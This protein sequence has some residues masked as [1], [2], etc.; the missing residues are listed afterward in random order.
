M[1]FDSQK[2][3]TTQ[4]QKTVSIEVN[5]E[6]SVFTSAGTDDFNQKQKKKTGEK[7]RKEKK[8]NTVVS[9]KIK[10]LLSIEVEHRMLTP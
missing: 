5:L 1:A 7:N 6:N 2:Q 8:K 9:I 3:E 4:K 10:S